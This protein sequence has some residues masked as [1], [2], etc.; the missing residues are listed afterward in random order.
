MSIRI[1]AWFALQIS[2]LAFTKIF[3]GLISEASARRNVKSPEFKFKIVVCGVVT[4]S[5]FETK[6]C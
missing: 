2:N 6:G 1:K 3:I 4:S 5:S